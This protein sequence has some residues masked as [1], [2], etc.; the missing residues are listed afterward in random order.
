MFKK[1]IIMI[2]TLLLCAS[3]ASCMT[4][5]EE[6]T[7]EVIELE[8]RKDRL[9]VEVA[10]LEAKKSQL[11]EDI[12][13]IKVENNIAKYIITI[14]IRQ[15]FH[16]SWDPLKTEIPVSKEFYESVA[17]GEVIETKWTHLSVGSES[18]R[19]RMEIVVRDKEIR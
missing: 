12:T 8:S 10:D 19:V 2:L 7:A 6:L 1:V 13:N 3:C 17:V 4:K 18:G 5:E 15:P 14:E 9:E 11:Q 16:L